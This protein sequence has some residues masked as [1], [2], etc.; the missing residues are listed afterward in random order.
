MKV[1]VVLDMFKTFIRYVL[2]YYTGSLL[3]QYSCLV[4]HCSYLAFQCANLLLY[5]LLFSVQSL[6][7]YF[8]LGSLCPPAVFLTKYDRKLHRESGRVE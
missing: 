7:L 4:Q 8:L 6:L 2:Y 1:R 3:V 5:F